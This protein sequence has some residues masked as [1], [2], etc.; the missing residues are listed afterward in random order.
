M[1][2]SQLFEAS[3]LK[4]IIYIADPEILAI[5]IIESHEE[6]LDLKK[7]NELQF[8]P[9]PETPLTEPHYTLIRKTV[10]EKL[11]QAQKDLPNNWRFRIYEAFRSIEVQKMLFDQEYQL[12]KNKSP[13]KSEAE[14]FHEATRLASPVINFDGTKN[15]PP[16][17][18][19]SAVDV[20]IID[21]N[22]RV[23]EMGM[24]AK[25]WQIVD[26]NLCMT[27]CENLDKAI[28]KNRD[29]L[30]AVMSAHD[31]VNY[32]TEWWHFS[33]GDRY[34][35]FHKNKSHAIYGAVK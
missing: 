13:E 32:P 19:G 2:I 9:P 30:F 31:F 33:Y 27:H 5:P 3:Y 4:K 14:I 15:I 22:G 8:G 25:D 16:H 28:Q 35:A 18:T 6:M 11:C 29:I 21:K 1:Q 20:E 10:Y 34:W 24:Q 17:N 7:Q 26:P 23:I 12:V